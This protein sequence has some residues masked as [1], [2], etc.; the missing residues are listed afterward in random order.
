[1]LG[2][3]RIRAWHYTPRANDKVERFIK[4]L[5]KE[6]ANAMPFQNSQQRDAWRPG[7]LSTYN[8]IRK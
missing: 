1:M 8:R 7:Y 5:C 3:K 2:L 4:T 6:L